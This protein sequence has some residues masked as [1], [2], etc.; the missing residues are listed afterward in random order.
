MKRISK[1]IGFRVFI[2]YIGVLI[3]GM[4]LC[5]ILVSRYVTGFLREKTIETNVRSMSAVVYELDSFYDKLEQFISTLY[6]QDIWKVVTESSSP[7]TYEILKR[8]LEFEESIH[9]L[10]LTSG[11]KSNITGMFLYLDDENFY[12][13]GDGIIRKELVPS[14]TDWFQSFIGS[15]KPITVAGPILFSDRLY[16]Y[17]NDASLL[18]IKR[19]NLSSRKG[20]DQTPF[21]MAVVQFEWLQSYF[22]AF[23]GDAGTVV[24]TSDGTIVYTSHVAYFMA[25]EIAARQAEGAFRQD[26]EGRSFYSDGEMLVTSI[27]A[28]RYDWY[29]SEVSPQRDIFA[30][31][32][33]VMWTIIAIFSACAVS[34]IVA[35]WFFSRHATI[36]VRTL[37]DMIAQME[38]GD[39]TFIE[40]KSSDEVGQIGMRFNSM[41]RSLQD[42]ANRTYSAQVREK[43]AQLQALQAQINPHFL[44]NTLDNVYCMAQVEGIEPIADLVQSLSSMLRYSIDNLDLYAP[45]QDELEHARKYV[46]IINLRYEGAIDYVEKA[47][48]NLLRFPVIKLLLQPIVE[49]AWTHGIAKKSSRRGSVWIEARLTSENCLLI[50][51]EDD[52]VGIPSETVELLNESL[53]Q[54]PSSVS[55]SGPNFGIALRNVNERIQ[56]EY[57]KA[58]GISISSVEGTGCKVEIRLRGE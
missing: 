10:L 23:F 35:A 32:A 52:G 46:S 51:V 40:I 54:E 41:K 9:N 29:I 14:Q 22:N 5:G 50:I 31:A 17:K 55:D 37:N 58:Y 7:L 6:D 53:R 20:R 28:P 30:D 44:Y 26:G 33:K 27:Y 11:L 48:P 21:V 57:G 1:S 43:Q 2:G 34:G 15:G 24:T 38:E 49:N 45:L 19:L 4:I 39:D 47:D 36:P 12:Y 16:A 3:L 13:V 25:E 42:A 18:Y 8:Q 56:L